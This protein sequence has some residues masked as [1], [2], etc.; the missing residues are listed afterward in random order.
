MVVNV[1]WFFLS[2]RLPIALAAKENGYEVTIVAADTGKRIE[3]ESYGLNFIEV[4]FERSGTNPLHELK[5]IYLL[6]NLYLK[7]KPDVIHHVT[8]K[9]SLLGSLAAKLSRMKHVINAISGFGYTFTDNRKGLLQSIVQRMIYYSFKSDTFR[10][11]LQNPDDVAMV[12]NLHLV[13]ENHI[14]LIKG[15]GV[16]LNQYKFSELPNDDVVSILFP[17]RI[18]EDKGVLELIDAAKSLK[19]RIQKNVVFILAGDCDNANLAVINE[20]KLKSLID[21]TYIK[22]IGY[23]K[24]MI[25]VFEKSHIVILPS[26]REGLPK[27]LIEA[28]AIGRPIITTNVPGCKECVIDN[29]NGLL[30]TVKDVKSLADAI[31]KLV[32]D[33]SLCEKYGRNSRNLAEKEFS[34]ES[35]ISKTLQVYRFEN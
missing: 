23:Q 15:S 21:G 13:P 5:C 6:R 17:A 3:I 8:L 7:H 32:D 24:D 34:L 9:A 31:M 10:F 22:W 11:I 4:P 29:Y 26:Y 28:A 27:A 33:K 35:V 20:T 19:N 25:S 14:T 16:D 1:D 18:L 2:H 12:H 30:V